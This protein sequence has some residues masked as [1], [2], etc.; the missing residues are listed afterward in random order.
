[1]GFKSVAYDAVLESTIVLPNSSLP[2]GSTIF[3]YL[4]LD[5]SGPQQIDS[6]GVRALETVGTAAGEVSLFLGSQL[7][8]TTGDAVDSTELNPFDFL[9][10]SLW[11]SFD[12]GQR[13]GMFLSMTFENGDQIGFQAEYTF[14]SVRIVP[15]PGAELLL[16]GALVGLTSL[17]RR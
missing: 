1:M 8:S 5:S 14:N 13:T 10:L 2:S 9:D 3:D 7:Y 4:V 11:D 15:V 16:L 12:D 17:R 6:V